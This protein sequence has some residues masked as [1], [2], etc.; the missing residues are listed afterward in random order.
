MSSSLFKL[1]DIY[2]TILEDIGYETRTRQQGKTPSH[3]ARL[4]RGE[5][6]GIQKMGTVGQT[7]TRRKL[8]PFML[9]KAWLG[10]RIVQRL[11]LFRAS[12]QHASGPGIFHFARAP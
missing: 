2:Q 9:I 10:G 12:R 7:S 11:R 4:P 3:P 1:F 6:Q 5:P 8:S